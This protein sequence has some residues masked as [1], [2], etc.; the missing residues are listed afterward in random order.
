ME[1]KRMVL[2]ASV[3]L[4]ISLLAATGA[5]Q[6]AGRG[7]LTPTVPVKT[8]VWL[9]LTATDAASIPTTTSTATLTRTPSATPT[10]NATPNYTATYEQEFE[11]ARMTVTAQ[12]WTQVPEQTLPSSASGVQPTDLVAV[13]GGTFM[14]GTTTEEATQALDECAL[15]GRTCDNFTWVEDSIPVHAV[16]VDSFE[17]ETYEVTVAQYVAFL[18][19]MGPNSHQYNC[20][21]MPCAV[22]QMEQNTSTITFD[23]QTYGVFNANFYS[24][25]PA[26]MITWYGAQAYCMALGRRL[27]T[28][29]EW[30]RAARGAQNLI[31]PWG[32]T[33]DESYAN[34]AIPESAG[35]VPV[36]SYPIGTSPYGIYNMAGNVSEWTADWYQG[37]WYSEQAVTPQANPT[38]PAMG[39]EKVLRGGAWDTIPLFARSVHRM[40]ADPYTATSAIGF[41]CVAGGGVTLPTATPTTIP[42]LT[43]TPGGTPQHPAAVPQT[44]TRPASPTTQP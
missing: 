3:I 38:G 10:T 31:Y 2:C 29:A 4:V 21:G 42:T 15:Y 34:T 26:T 11:W 19:S 35:T 27:P 8:Q 23:N 40:S 16:T 9:D 6:S 5:A 39:S 20:L 14:M 44:P 22:T 28:E 41:R 37:N 18:N 32:Y 1:S 43:F 12:N 30:E 24:N 33:F 7:M 36:D 13:T 25:H 17:I